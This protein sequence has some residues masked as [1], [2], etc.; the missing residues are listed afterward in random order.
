MPNCNQ[1]RKD[2]GNA[3]NVNVFDELEAEYLRRRSEAIVDL[4]YGLEKLR[5]LRGDLITCASVQPIGRRD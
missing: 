4:L 5:R 2:S 1:C 3:L